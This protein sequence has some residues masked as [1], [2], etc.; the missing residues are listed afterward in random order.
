MSTISD[1][2]GTAGRIAGFIGRGKAY[3]RIVAEVEKVRKTHTTSIIV[4]GETGTGKE[5]IARSIHFCG[6]RSGGPFIPLNCATIPLELAESC[7]FGHVPGAFTGASAERKGYFEMADGGTLFL[8]EIG[9]MPP[10]LQVKML[11][12]LEDQTFMKVGSDR[13]RS[14]DVRII[15]ATNADLYQQMDAVRFRR[16]LFYRLARFI[17]DVPPLRRRKEDIPLL[18]RHFADRFA[19]EMRTDPPRIGAEAMDIL[20]SHPFSGNVRELKNVIEHAMIVCGGATILPGHL[21]FAGP[22][23]GTDP[24]GGARRSFGEHAPAIPRVSLPPD[25]METI[26]IKGALAHERGN[27]TAA[28]GLLK[29]S[30]DRVRRIACRMDGKIVQ[31]RIVSDEDRIRDHLRRRGSINNTECRKLLDVHLNRASYLLKKMT[32]TGELKKEKGGRWTRYR[33]AEERANSLP[34]DR[35]DYE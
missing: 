24:A 33:L 20:L 3:R 25:Q 19:S 14:V 23:A 1:H 34:M 13:E 5:L 29:V 30:P 16:D 8:D 17:I 28:A 27:I 4:Q 7:L 18:A 9:D 26:M 2:S 32:R 6:P 11:R 22:V 21:R 12:V 15:A 31:G 10:D 35:M